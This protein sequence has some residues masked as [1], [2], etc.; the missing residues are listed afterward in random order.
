MV[1]RYLG[2]SGLLVSPIGFGAFKIGR[3]TG[4]KYAQGYEL[5][6]D[7]EVDRL[8]G[9]LLE[10]GVNLFDTAPAYGRSEEGL[11]RAL[12]GRR[13]EVVLCTKAGETYQRGRSSYDFS[14]GAVRATI[15]GSLKRLRTDVLDILLVH[16]DGRDTDIMTATDVV[17]TLQEARS[18]GQARL[19]G[20]SAKTR[21]GARAAL[22]WA[23]VIMV[24][25]HVEDRAAEPVIAEAATKGV[26]VLVKKGLASGRLDAA[27][28]IRFALANPG[29]SS[30][31]VGSLSLD[32]MRANVEASAPGSS[33]SS[34][35]STGPDR[36]R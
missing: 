17:A 10:L 6:T 21:E 31:I 27:G 32:H 11:G 26:G 24:E 25:Y 1:K 14:G 19:I 36:P 3:N 12:R 28:S 16:S 30:V 4:T 18:R 2:A 15:V 23:D 33:A 22:A 29:V 9:G 5:P 34:R 13:D 20:L 8:V 35:S 7:A